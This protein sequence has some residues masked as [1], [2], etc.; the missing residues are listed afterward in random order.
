MQAEQGFLKNGSPVCA[1]WGPGLYRGLFTWHIGKP[2]KDLLRV[3]QSHK[4]LDNRK[5]LQ[6]AVDTTDHRGPETSVCSFVCLF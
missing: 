5:G 2:Y 3:W 1:K 4:V 6:D